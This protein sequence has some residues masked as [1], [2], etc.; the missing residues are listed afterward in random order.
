MLTSSHHLPS[1]TKLY[2]LITV[3]TL[4]LALLIL[5]APQTLCLNG[6]FNNNHWDINRRRV[7]PLQVSKI[8]WISAVVELERQS[9]LLNDRIQNG[10]ISNDHLYSL[11]SSTIYDAC[12]RNYKVQTPEVIQQPNFVNCT[13]KYK[14]IAQINRFT[15]ETL[16][17]GIP[18][19]TCKV[20]LEN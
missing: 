16:Q 8:D 2:T 9:H 11:I 6:A 7:A 17:D 19:D 13:S 18:F 5:C 1:W 20:Y 4:L 14:A 12:K 10:N 15:H 3:Q